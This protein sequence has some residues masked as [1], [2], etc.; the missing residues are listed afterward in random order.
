[1]TLEQA[2]N[3]A[4]EKLPQQWTI[5]ISVG[6]GEGGVQAER[7]DGSVVDM[8]QDET[9]FAEQ[10][11]AAVRLAHDE[12]EADKLSRLAPVIQDQLGRG[13][14]SE[15]LQEHCG[16]P[17]SLSVEERKLQEL[18]REYHTRTEAYDRTVCTGP[19]LHGAIMP[20]TPHER[21]LINNNAELVRDEL[22]A[23]AALL[24]FTQQQ[25]REALLRVEEES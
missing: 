22:G 3:Y 15:F 8:Y 2:L 24:G 20:S 18:A 9:D 1:M 7:P 17:S 14:A 16:I 11:C 19:I 4:A 13:K 21:R 25:W 12:E 5:N 10:V 23:K 6:Q